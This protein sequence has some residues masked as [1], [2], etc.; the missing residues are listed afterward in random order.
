MELDDKELTRFFMMSDLSKQLGGKLELDERHQ[1]CYSGDCEGN[2]DDLCR[3]FR[4]LIGPAAKVVVRPPM[5]TE[6]ADFMVRVRNYT[7]ANSVK[8][9]HT[10]KDRMADEMD[11]FNNF[12]DRRIKNAPGPTI[13]AYRQRV[14]VDPPAAK[15]KICDD[16]AMRYYTNL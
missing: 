13:S 10:I 5:S 15:C 6:W 12:I 14:A 4:A 9:Y 7:N 2:C 3:S 16:N 11:E 1:I 8:Q